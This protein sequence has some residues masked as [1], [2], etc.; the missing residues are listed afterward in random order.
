M[1]GCFTIEELISGYYERAFSQVESASPPHFSRR[2]KRRMKEI[3][4][5]KAENEAGGKTYAGKVFRKPMSIRKRIIIAAVIVIFMAILTGA[6]SAFV[7]GNFGATI[8]GDSVYI[9]VNLDDSCPRVIE[10]VYYLADL[11]G[12]YTEKRKV[13]GGKY[14]RNI[15]Y[16]DDEYNMISLSQF[17]R[18]N[19]IMRFTVAKDMIEKT[20]VNGSDALCADLNSSNW[21][22]SFVIWANDGY[23]FVLIGENIPSG[24]IVEIAEECVQRWE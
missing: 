17:T 24:E 11:P 20:S 9:T 23:I 7:S 15:S 12:G 16:Y 13:Q 22:H 19:F 3:L 21:P 5:V 1:N 18:E 8:S 4:S 2:H 6:V 10:N 14:N